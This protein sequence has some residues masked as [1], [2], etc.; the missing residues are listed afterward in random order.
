MT[1]KTYLTSFATEDFK[2]SQEVLKCSSLV[3]GGVDYVI[4][5]NDKSPEIVEFIKQNHS[6]FYKDGKITRGFGFWSWQPFITL[7]T[8][9]L[10]NYGD[11]LIYM[12]SAINVIRDINDIISLSREKGILLFKLGEHS[13]K[14][15]RNFVWTKRDTFSVMGITDHSSSN[16]SQLTA[17]VQ[18]YVKSNETIRFLEEFMN[19]CKIPMAIADSSHSGTILDST[20]KP[21]PENIGFKDHRHNQSILSILAE[22]YNIYRIRDP[23][24]WGIHDS[25]DHMFPQSIIHHRQKINKLPKITVIT[26]TTGSDHLERCIRS[27]QAQNVPNIEHMIVID[28]PEFYDRSMNI[29]NKFSNKRPIHVV[30]L[31]YNVGSNGWNGHRVYGSMPHICISDLISYMDDDNW[32]DQDHLYNLL[33]KLSKEDLDAAHSLRAIYNQEG[34]EFITN[35]NCESLGVFHHSI[36]SENEKFIDTSCYLMKKNV[37]ISVGPFWNKPFRPKGMTEP[38]RDVANVIMNNFKVGGVGKYTVS[39]PVANTERSVKGDFF[40]QGNK[41]MSQLIGTDMFPWTE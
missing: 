2:Y 29:I 15:Y 20:G 32:Y 28:G 22:K 30:K 10:M 9:E 23:S 14:D 19:Y 8:M 1:S 38:D 18:V 3:N 34:T 31:P 40:L 6:L 33:N 7:K 25:D 27:V 41:A 13:N 39:Y 12:D 11:V 26:P 36:L 17:S 5:W 24:Q 35:D 21:F 16:Y 37:A 4:N